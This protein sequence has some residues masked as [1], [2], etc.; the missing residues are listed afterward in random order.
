MNRVSTAGRIHVDVKHFYNSDICTLH[1]VVSTLA[2][3]SAGPRFDAK[4]ESQLF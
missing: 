4:A 1:D 2:S 3:K